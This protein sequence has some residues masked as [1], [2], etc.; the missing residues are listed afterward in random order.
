[1]L[2]VVLVLLS[3][4]HE[5]SCIPVQPVCITVLLFNNLLYRDLNKY[6]S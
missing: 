6:T 4:W 3:Y 5:G 1:M 2:L